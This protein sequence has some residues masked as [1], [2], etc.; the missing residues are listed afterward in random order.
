MKQLT[1]TINGKELSVKQSFRSLMEF[2]KMTGR[3]AYEFNP[4]V[5]DSLT[6]F[7]CILKAANRE[8][9]DYSFDD[10][11]G[12][13]DEN[14]KALEDFNEYVTKLAEEN[15]KAANKGTKKKSR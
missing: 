11:L 12:L 2:E 5:T 1:I 6:I 7:Y 10:F 15:L 8:T 14:P 13:L 4:G 9:F 3:N